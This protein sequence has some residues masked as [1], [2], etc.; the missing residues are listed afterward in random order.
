MPWPWPYRWPAGVTTLPTG[1]RYVS[2]A[3]AGPDPTSAVAA[4]IVVVA[5][6]D[7]ARP[8]RRCLA[9]NMS[10]P[11]STTDRLSGGE[12]AGAV[13]RIEPQ[14]SVGGAGHEGRPAVAVLVTHV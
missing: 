4:T 6:R 8:A 13:S 14:P 10:G 11:L 3:V 12:G 9:N 7:S 2:T 5:A 1:R